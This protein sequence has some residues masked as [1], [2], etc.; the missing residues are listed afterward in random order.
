M[1]ARLPGIAFVTAASPLAEALPR[2][3]IACF[4]GFA[5]RGPV[6]TPVAVD[7]PEQYH[8]VFGA[9]LPLVWDAR[10]GELENGELLHA[11]LGPAVRAFFA[12]GGQRAWVIRVAEGPRAN[13]FPVPGLCRPVPG[14][15]LLPA[16]LAAAS[17]GSWSDGLSLASSLDLA[18][19]MPLSAELADGRLRLALRAGEILMP[20]DLLRAEWDDGRIAFLPYQ[21]E[22][23]ESDAD[24]G[25]IPWRDILWFR[26]PT[27]PSR[28]RQGHGRLY[29]IGH[30]VA[31]RRRFPLRASPDW[32]GDRPVLEADLP[33]DRAPHPGETLKARLGSAEYW[34]QVESCA[35]AAA[36]GYRITGRG[37]RRLAPPPAAWP[38]RPARLVRLRLDLHVAEAGQATTQLRG[39]G[40]CDR[41]P[42]A[43]AHLAGDTLAW[44]G[45]VSAGAGIHSGIHSGIHFLPLGLD[46]SPGP[47]QGAIP[48]AASRLTRDG[49]KQ[50]GAHLFLDPALAATRA[51]DMA[52]AADRIRYTGAHPRPLRGL[53]AALGLEE[54]TLLCVPDAVHRPWQRVPGEEHPAP[55]D[56][57][58]LPAPAN[59]CAHGQP[60]DGAFAPCLPAKL[61]PPDLAADPAD[62]LG[63]VRL[64]WNDAATAEPSAV[65]ILEEARDPAWR[66]A[67]EIHRGPGSE[68]TL[69]DRQHGDYFY[70]LRFESAAAW[71]DWSPG[72]A[73]RIDPAAGWKIDEA[74]DYR[75]ADLLAIQRALARLAAARGDCLAVLAL[76]RHYRQR[77]ALE[78][79][80]RLKGDAPARFDLDADNALE[81]PPLSL[82]EAAAWS[83]AALYHPWLRRLDAAD[84]PALPPDGPATGLLAR[85]ALER[86]A[87]I[88]PANLLLAGIGGLD[89]PFPGNA[90]VLAAGV[91]PIGHAINLGGQRFIVLDAL[92]LSDDPETQHINVR[93]LMCL[94]R[95]LVLKQ[96]A[97][98]V[99]E[100]NSEAL[101]RAIDSRF[102]H[103]LDDL[104]ARGAFA[105]QRPQDAYHLRVD[106][107]VNPPQGIDAGRLVIE[108]GVAPARPLRFLTVRLVQ[109]GERLSLAEA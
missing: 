48:L 30:G 42:N 14:G 90:A 33:A 7:G 23:L 99:F 59:A 76:P 45:A 73:L 52:E 1:T 13:R 95:R 15:R 97:R 102:R 20:G 21:G 81:V 82:G 11:H 88:A 67:A 89:V 109:S 49:L 72:L 94:L 86:G 68:F 70:R 10:P 36:G 75:D 4:V 19:V 16:H 91:N 92:T 100:P 31:Y 9:D 98:F 22:G 104:Y 78:H 25:A 77:Q 105:G 51:P 103:W 62:A 43:L 80:R 3:D 47:A 106:A 38:N 54:V 40:F 5:P 24:D 84:L 32:Q 79:V 83:H 26:Q 50:F 87:W 2:M 8:R 101:R 96:G 56:S 53:H 61:P 46:T 37:L 58:P 108:I 85:R 74:A 57:D 107:S 17:S 39:L 71:S 66:D 12:N 27:L 29:R 63:A 93:R 44:R 60:G 65:Y 41:H 6:H 28:A 69:R 64:H 55:R 34:L 18:P 35:P